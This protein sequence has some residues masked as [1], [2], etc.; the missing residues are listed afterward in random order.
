MRPCNYPWH[1]GVTGN[2]ALFC[3]KTKKVRPIFGQQRDPK[4]EPQWQPQFSS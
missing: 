1:I 2:F 4:G 3:K